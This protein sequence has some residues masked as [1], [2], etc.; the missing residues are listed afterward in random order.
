MT[1]VVDEDSQNK[2]KQTKP[3][4]I[5]MQFFSF[6]LNQPRKDQ[7]A[8]LFACSEDPAQLPINVRNGSETNFPTSTCHRSFKCA[9]SD[10]AMVVI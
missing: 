6:A 3:K 4:T 5:I 9:V 10:I 8:Q 7:Q 2:E 1:N